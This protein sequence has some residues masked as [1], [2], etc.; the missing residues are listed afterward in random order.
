M[1]QPSRS[2]FAVLAVLIGVLIALWPYPASLAPAVAAGEKPALLPAHRTDVTAARP[3]QETFD[4]FAWQL[5]V[6]L[7]WPARKDGKPD[8]SKVIGQAP[9]APRVWDF[10]S[11]AEE[12]FHSSSLC[13]D[14]KASPDLKVLRMFRDTTDSGTDVQAGSSWPLVDQDKNF[15]PVEIVVNDVHQRYLV[16][17]GLTTPAGL[18]KYIEHNTIFFPQGSMELKAAWRLFPANTN[19]QILARYHTKKAVIC[20]ASQQ[21]EN[22][23]P[24]SVAGTVGLVGLHIVYKTRN[25]P[26]WIWSTFEQVD[27]E[28]VSYKPLPGLKPTFS[29]GTSTHGCTDETN[30]PPAPVPAS[31]MLY[32]WAATQPTAHSYSPTQAAKCANETPLPEAVNARFQAALAGVHGVPNSPWQYYRLIATQWFDA[33]NRL[34]PKNGDGAAVS[35]NSTLETYLMGDQT[36]AGQVPT[37][38]PVVFDP[39][40]FPPPNSTLTDT[41]QATITA[42]KPAGPYTWSSCVVCHQMAA[43]QY[44][45]DPKTTKDRVMTDFSFVFRSNLTAGNAAPAEKEDVKKNWLSTKG[46]RRN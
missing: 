38:G 2:K 8:L 27:N 13:P 25:Q 33:R 12:I 41:I 5:F 14:Q 39:P 35:R 23:Q 32:K 10:F 19:P 1:S 20:V 24:F 17:N 30:R 44:G 9:G 42:Q 4:N 21:S 3:D 31:K 36:I 45:P 7:N 15:S 46:S 18:K 28:E 40:N 43:Y 37:L 11:N 26:R 22:G 34:Q 6:A 29:D 16:R